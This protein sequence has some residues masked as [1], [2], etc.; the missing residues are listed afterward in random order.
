MRIRRGLL[1]GGL[2]FITV[3]GINLLVR[4][5]VIDANQLDDAWQLWP[6]I[7]VGVGITLLLGRRRLA[8]VGTIVTALV[9]G[10]IVGGAIASGGNWIVNL[11][12]CG[13]SQPG[14]QTTSEA[15]GFVGPSTIDLDFRC[16]TLTVTTDPGAGW[17]FGATYRGPAPEIEGTA[18]QMQAR[19]PEGSGIR[20]QDWTL[21]A[22]TE[23][24]SDLQ[25]QTNA[26]T[27]DIT[28]AGA[29]LGAFGLQSNAGDVRVDGTGA[30]LQ[31]IDVQVN[32]ARLRLTL[33][34]DSS[35]ELH[36]NAGAIDLCVP[37]SAAL[38]F[39]VPSQ[40]TFATN[41]ADRGLTQNGTIWTRAGAATSDGTSPGSIDLR[42]EGNA[43]SFTLD[44]DG[45]CR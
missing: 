32:A 20:R 45:G 38:R 22:G 28:L 9:V 16:G 19:V 29:K 34:E 15:G 10:A 44:P 14:D 27:A 37:P 39:D 33:D 40:I 23:A 18:S 3:G 42:V 1:F 21:S 8:I 43:A 35:G 26:G 7:L 12:D 30:S 17:S 41:L 4:A 13:G 11:T 6:L 5:G 24:L 25:V 36:V 31:G 2:F